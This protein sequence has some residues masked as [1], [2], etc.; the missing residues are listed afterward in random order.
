[1]QALKLGLEALSYLEEIRN[2]I[3]GMAERPKIGETPSTP[4]PA[5][6]RAARGDTE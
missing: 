3:N 5:Q 1:M 6:E 2:R 4:S